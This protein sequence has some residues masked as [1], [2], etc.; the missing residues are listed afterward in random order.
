MQSINGI[1][2]LARPST[3]ASRHISVASRGDNREASRN[4]DVRT[5]A[6]KRGHEQ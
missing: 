4:G 5:K 6:V 1:L 3:S 2:N